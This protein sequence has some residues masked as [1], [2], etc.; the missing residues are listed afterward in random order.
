MQTVFIILQVVSAI[1]LAVLILLQ[2]RGSGMGE[3]IGGTGGTGF[4]TSKRGAEK[5]LAQA[6]VVVLVA[7]LLISLA[8]NFI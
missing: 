2:E 6:T 7:F 4:Q 1:A 5:I 8:L 3:A